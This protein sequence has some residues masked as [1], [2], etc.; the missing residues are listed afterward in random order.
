MLRSTLETFS[1]GFGTGMEQLA[2]RRLLN[3]R[4][5]NL[6]SA[7]RAYYDHMKHAAKMIF[8]KDARYDEII[9][10]FSY[11]Y[12]QN[13]SYRV[14]EALRNYSQHCGL[15]IHS[16]GYRTKVLR[17]KKGAPLKHTI[18]PNLDVGRLKSDDQFKASVLRELESKSN[19]QAID[20]K[21]FTRNYV[22][23]LAEVHELFRTYAASVTSAANEQL[24]GF[25][26]MYSRQSPDQDVRMGLYAV[27]F[28]GNSWNKRIP[29][30]SGLWEYGEYLVNT[31][32]HFVH[33]GIWFVS[34]ELDGA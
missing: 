4:I 16:V 25:V 29:L 18:S 11:H 21:A 28:E 10:S 1:V 12:D 6:L 2:I 24:E 17:D 34:G 27:A 8:N 23:C 22:M 15:P 32:L 33:A 19:S 13:L 7:T 20:L 5:S 31:N 26:K 3:R 14:M 9:T 30:F